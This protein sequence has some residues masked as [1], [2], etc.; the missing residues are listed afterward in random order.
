MKYKIV[1]QNPRLLLVF[2][3]DDL[4]LGN[5]IRHSSGICKMIDNIQSKFSLAIDIPFRFRGVEFSRLNNIIENGIDVLPITSTI[6][7]SDDPCKSMEYGWADNKMIL[8]MYDSRLIER[9]FREV[10][11]NT[12]DEEVKKI[13]E[14]YPTRYDTA[15]GTIWLSRLAADDKRMFS[16]YEAYYAGWIPQNHFS[17]LIG[18]IFIGKFEAEELNNLETKLKSSQLCVKYEK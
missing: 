10:P 12:S 4:E 5:S 14:T 13:Q 15:D 8:L 18:I 7:I 16:P 1:Q 6:Y 2:M 11:I 3:L 9:T 17:A